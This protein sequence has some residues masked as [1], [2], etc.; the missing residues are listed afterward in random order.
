MHF[1]SNLLLLFF[2]LISVLCHI[3]RQDYFASRPDN[4]TCSNG[5]LCEVTLNCYP[6][7]R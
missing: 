3:V 5:Q 4:V 1:L 6:F 7:I 2:F